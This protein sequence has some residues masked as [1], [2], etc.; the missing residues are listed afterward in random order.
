MKSS[1]SDMVKLERELSPGKA[2]T[3]LKSDLF[4]RCKVQMAPVEVELG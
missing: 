1:S 4:S 3:G 2:S